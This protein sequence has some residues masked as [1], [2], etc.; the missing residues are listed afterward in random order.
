MIPAGFKGSPWHCPLSTA[1]GRCR[2]ESRSLAAKLILKGILDPE[3][4]RMAL[5]R[6]ADAIIVSNHGGRQ[7]DGAR[8]PISALPDV[9]RAVK[10]GAEVHLDGGIRSGP[11]VLKAVALGAKGFMWDARSSGASGRAGERA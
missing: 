4:A 6:G 10:G 9:V 1:K 11:N 3:D 7:L 2:V 8:S 5:G